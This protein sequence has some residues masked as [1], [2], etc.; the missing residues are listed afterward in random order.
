MR[1]LP[2]LVPALALLAGA[3]LVAVEHRRTA[4]LR[5]AAEAQ[6]TENRL[7]KLADEQAGLRERAPDDATWERLTADA[8][9]AG[10]LRARVVELWSRVE[11]KS[12]AAPSAPSPWRDEG[13]ADPRATLHTAIW[14]AQGGDVD[15]LARLI[16]F[17]PAG[18]AR[19]RATFDALPA[20]ARAQY[21]DPEHVIATLAAVRI[22]LGLE[23]ATVTRE[24]GNQAD[25]V[26]LTADLRRT[27]GKPRAVTLTF[28]RE[29][30]AWKLVVPD[31]AVARY[32]RILRGR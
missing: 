4:R 10:Q 7:A 24:E 30:D 15:A 12:R 1:T 6:P 20:E 13:N 8:E 9:V 32:E 23:S 14:A 26:A 21:Q 31:R 27:G 16:T 2:I 19:A 25:R 22:P 17:N 3:S 18:R 29:G 5:R 11:M 28:Q